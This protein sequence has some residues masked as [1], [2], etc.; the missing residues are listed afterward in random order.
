MVMLAHAFLTVRATVMNAAGLT[1]DEAG[2][3]AV[4]LA[5]ARPLFTTLLA[6]TTA[7][8]EQILAWSR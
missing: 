1:T 6:R 7:T 5:E 3:I 4:R 2:L 8:P